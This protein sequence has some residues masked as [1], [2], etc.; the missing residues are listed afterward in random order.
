MRGELV[1]TK[2]LRVLDGSF[3][4][5]LTQLGVVPIITLPDASVAASLAAALIEGGITGAGDHVAHA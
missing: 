3:D 4:Q 2:D 5:K 1:R